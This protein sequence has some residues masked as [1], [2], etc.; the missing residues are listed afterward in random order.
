MSGAPLAVTS[1]SVAAFRLRAMHLAARLPADRLVE[2]TAG[3]LQDTAPRAALVALHARVE[4]LGPAAWEAPGLVQVWFRGGAVYVVPRDDVGVFTLGAL[5]RD[6]G[7]AADMQRQ[8]DKVVRA[9]DGQAMTAR[10]LGAAVPEVGVLGVKLYGPTGKYLIRW[11][12]RMTYILP[13]TPAAVDAEEA[14][15]ELGRR[16][17]RWLGPSDAARFRKW[18]GVPREDAEAT[19]DALAGTGELAPVDVEGH[20]RWLLAA[21]EAALRSVSVGPEVVRLLPMGDPWLYPEPDGVVPPVP[22]AVADRKPGPGVTQRLLNS[23]AGRVVAGTEVV[24]SWGRVGGKVTIAP[25][26]ALS[27]EESARLDEEARST[28]GVLDRPVTVRWL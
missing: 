28:A 12:A 15:L 14:R 8:A 17:L 20:R 22:P 16:F 11:D 2:A 5:P 4:G 21:D 10:Q 24:A 9:L 3:G 6:P 19:W 1:A 13:A 18:A 23:L 27:D 7:V 25:W 26:R